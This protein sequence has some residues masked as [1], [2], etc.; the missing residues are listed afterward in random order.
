MNA[1]LRT[2]TAPI[3]KWLDVHPALGIS[4]MDHLFNRLDGAYP[5][6]WRS[7]FASQDA[8]INWR[9][10]WAETFEEE[11]LTTAEV[12][13]GWKACRRLY[14]WP[15]SIAEF[16]RACRPALDPLAA[17]HEALSGLAAREAGEIGLW[18][19]PAVYWAAVGMAYDLKMQTHGQIKGRWERAL[20]EQSAKGQWEPIPA[21][22]LQIG[23]SAGTRTTSG[24]E[25]VVDEMRSAWKKADAQFD[26]KR[27]ARRILERVES[28]DK[29]INL[30]Q[31]KSANEA[32]GIQG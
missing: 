32:L 1:P 6:K 25:G 13:T 11:N 28:G 2:S 29:A 5:H 26:H 27:W 19:S 9:E 10:S 7:A 24:T 8:I 12:Q 15:P 22:M 3:S 30:M 23:V 16:L 17:Y 4:M 14:D 21:P 20:A 18:S 31:L